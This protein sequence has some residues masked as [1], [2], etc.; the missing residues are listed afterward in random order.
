MNA[1][2]DNELSFEEIITFAK[3]NL[4]KKGYLAVI[5][6]AIESESFL[7]C[8]ILQELNLIQRISIK[9]FPES[10]VIRNILLFSSKL[11]QLEDEMIVIYKE[12]KIKTNIYNDSH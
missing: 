1:R 4:S 6:P 8:C 7:T 3:L 11:N 5:L 12:E 9:S 2:H 10:K